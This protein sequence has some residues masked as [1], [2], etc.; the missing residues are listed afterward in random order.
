MSAYS[1]ETKRFT[2]GPGS[3]YTGVYLTKR[4]SCP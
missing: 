1:R 3:G 4:P 2:I